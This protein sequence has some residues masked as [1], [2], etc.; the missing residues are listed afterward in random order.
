METTLSVINQMP[1]NKEE[2]TLFV[3]KSVA[4][5]RDG[6]ANPLDVTI[7]LKYVEEAIKQIREQIADMAL[8][9]ADK[10]G[11]S[12][13]HLNTKIDIVYVGVKYDYSSCC[14]TGWDQL[15]VAD[16]NI[17]EKKKE[18]ESF[19]KTIKA[20]MQIADELT[21]GEEITVYPP[22]KSGRES[23]KITLK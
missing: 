14:D 18:R 4:M 8:N 16:K 7:Q 10:Y 19:L 17:T 13:E 6:M 9:E 11:K 2:I 23:L 20:P 22:I 1:Q 15:D 5:V 12:F 21:G 3:A